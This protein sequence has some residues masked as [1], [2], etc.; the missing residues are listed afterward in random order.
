[1]NSDAMELKTLIDGFK[2]S[3]LTEGKSAKTVEW[4]ATFLNRFRQFLEVRHL[5][6]NLGELGK[7]RVREFIRFLQTE[8]RNPRNGMP[9]SGATVQG[10]VRTLKAFFS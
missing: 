4:Y 8:A 3:C 5:P 2:L 9:L 6:T 7:D 1:M 10:Y